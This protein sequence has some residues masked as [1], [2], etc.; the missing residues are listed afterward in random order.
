MGLIWVCDECGKECGEP[1]EG[2]SELATGRVLFDGEDHGQGVML[3][4]DHRPRPGKHQPH[5]CKRV[6]FYWPG[7]PE[8]NDEEADLSTDQI[9]IDLQETKERVLAM[10][11]KEHRESCR[12]REKRR[13]VF[14]IAPKTMTV[15]NCPAG[16]AIDMAVA[17]VM[18]LQDLHWGDPR[19][20]SGGLG[21]YRPEEVGRVYFRDPCDGEIGLMPTYSTS[22]V[23]SGTLTEALCTAGFSCAHIHSPDYPGRI[24]D[25]RRV[26]ITGPHLDDS[27][28]IARAN[29]MGLAITRAYLKANGVTWVKR[30]PCGF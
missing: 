11:N 30:G 27:K 3:C 9:I 13:D 2:L 15:D 1:M 19:R 16:P 14:S 4:E 25:F 24:Y 29:T 20:C 23:A 22:L 10:M 6:R 17:K 18:G 7:M 12:A 21:Y 5:N 28:F 8:W 26:E